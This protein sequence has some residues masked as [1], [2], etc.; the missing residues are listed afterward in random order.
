M[1]EVYDTMEVPSEEPTTAPI[2]PR[3]PAPATPE[4]PADPALPSVLPEQQTSH[5]LGNALLTVQVP[6][7]TRVFV[8]GVPTKST[9]MVRRYVSRNLAPGY[10]YTYEVRAEANID[11]KPVVETKTVHMRAGQT[12]KLAFD[13]IGQ[14]NVETALT[15]NVPRDAKVFLAGNEAP[16]TGIQRTF[17]TTKL[18]QG[19]S[20]TDY[21]IRVQVDRNGK[22]MTKEQ[23]ITL[24]AGDS[25]ALTFQFGV[26]RLASAR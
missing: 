17:R 25:R 13:V 6:E 24:Q 5:R 12:A 10:H 14:T 23:T 15:L 8:N 21:A 3:A 22:T 26:D 1:G 11:G 9:G 4:L 19:N 18:S 2:P 7:G 16:G 20:W